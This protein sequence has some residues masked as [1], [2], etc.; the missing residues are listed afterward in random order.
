MRLLLFFVLTAY[1]YL[2]KDDGILGHSSGSVTLG[3]RE[4]VGHLLINDLVFSLGF[5]EMCA[6]FYVYVLLREDRQ[7]LAKQIVERKKMEEDML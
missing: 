7:S 5:L 6:W 1:T 3:R 4:G 2:F